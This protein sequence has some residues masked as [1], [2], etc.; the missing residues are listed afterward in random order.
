M[1]EQ[2][3]FYCA[4]PED[5]R[6][7]YARGTLRSLSLEPLAVVSETESRVCGRRYGRI[8]RALALTWKDDGDG[9]VDRLHDDG[10][11]LVEE[12]LY[13]PD[14]I[15]QYGSVRDA[16]TDGRTVVMDPESAREFFLFDV[17]PIR[18]T[19]RHAYFS[20]ARKLVGVRDDQAHF[21]T[22]DGLRSF[23]LGEIEWR[24]HE[25]VSPARSEWHWDGPIDA[26]STRTLAISDSWL[27]LLEGI[28]RL[29]VVALSESGPLEPA[30]LYSVSS[31]IAACHAGGE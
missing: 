17:D 2:R 20:G 30:R 22:D 4:A 10:S 15:H 9:W 7:S 14:G 8:E 3:L 19:F 21:I 29:L 1:S 23:E 31:P 6:R 11:S 28:D 26:E 25:W 24:S 13:N 12:Y 5:P 16:R 27:V 18:P